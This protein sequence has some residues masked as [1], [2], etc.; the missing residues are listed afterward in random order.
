M[1]SFL[2]FIF[3]INFCEVCSV[4]KKSTK[5]NYSLSPRV[6]PRI[7]RVL[8]TISRVDPRVVP[9]VGPSQVRV[10]P[11][12]KESHLRRPLSFCVVSNVDMDPQ[13]F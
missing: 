3:E 9:K 5:I 4:V 8:A 7:R 13:A 11:N 10:D 12:V 1:T 2:D 6:D